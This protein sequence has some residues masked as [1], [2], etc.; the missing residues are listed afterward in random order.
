MAVAAIKSTDS[1]KG[2]EAAGPQASPRRRI[3]LELTSLGQL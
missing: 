2:P 3:I 1:D